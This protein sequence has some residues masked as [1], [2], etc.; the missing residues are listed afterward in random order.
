VFIAILVVVQFVTSQF[1][2]TLIT[3]SLVNLILILSV[4]LCG[5][6]TG[7]TVA[8]LS[9]VFAK[10]IGIG[11]FWTIIPFILLGNLVLVTIWRKVG[12][13]E[14]PNRYAAWAIA[15]VCAAAVKFLI[16]FFGVTKWAIPVILGLPEPQATVMSA[17][18]SLPQLFTACIGGVLA[19]LL[20]PALK[21]ALHL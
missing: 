6:A 18:F 9:P 13:A 8:V 19:I 1:G 21:K 3:G 7:M 20:L 16:V 2:T 15:L 12:G 14:K 10:L 11:P 17:A 5:Q 4:M